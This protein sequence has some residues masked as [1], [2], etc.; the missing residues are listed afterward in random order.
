MQVICLNCG[1]AILETDVN[2]SADT[3]F[4]R[5]CES[6]TRLSEL[7]HE[8]AGGTSLADVDT[9]MPPRRCFSRDDGL[10]QIV[11]AGGGAGC[12]T[13]A[14]VL[15]FCLFWNAITGIF[16]LIALVST[17]QHMGVYLPAWFPAPDMDGDG[18]SLGE[19]MFMWCFL[20]P[21]ILIGLT[22]AGATVVALAGRVTVTFSPRDGSVLSGVA[23]I[24]WKR[25]FDPREVKSIQFGETKWEM[26]GA[27]Q[28]VL[29]L[30]M[31]NG[32]VIR[33]GSM[34]TEERRAWMA[35]ELRRLLVTEPAKAAR[36]L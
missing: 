32:K 12:G 33:F 29:Q 1:E 30:T 17:L 24:G 15:F 20:T 28:T 7:L 16:V 10:V 5:A 36:R 22:T 19:T 34:M 23:G 25:R 3:A 14:G 11:S 27:H 26:N 21:F 31:R 35:A 4:C 2:V 9:K 8:S 6:L 13:V 18:M